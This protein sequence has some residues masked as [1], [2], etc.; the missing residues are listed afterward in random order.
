[1]LIGIS[2]A[3]VELFLV[4]ILFRVWSWIAMLPE[5]F[6]EIVA[7]GVSTQPF[8]SSQFLRRDD[9]LYLI[10]PVPIVFALPF[11]IGLQLL[12]FE[13]PPEWSLVLAF[14]CLS[15]FLGLLA[16]LDGRRPGETNR[17]NYG[18]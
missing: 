3:A 7:F 16:G 11:L 2:L 1:M 9:E 10:C 5:N 14:L 15:R 8:E 4:F 18:H 6:D 13:R 12:A 17:E